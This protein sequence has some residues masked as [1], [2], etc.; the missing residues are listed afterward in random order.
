MQNLPVYLNKG[1]TP[2]AETPYDPATMNQA[3]PE[4]GLF[5]VID[6]IDDHDDNITHFLPTRL[7]GGPWNPSHQHGGAVSGLLTRAL[8]RI[9]SPVPMRLTRI[10]LEMFRGVP[11]TPLRVETRVLR[12]GRRIQ[13]VEASLFDKEMQVAR[14]SGLRIRCEP[15]MSIL[16]TSETLDPIL[17]VPP[18]G[19]VPPVEPRAG[20]EIP[21]GFVNAIDFVR[22]DAPKPGEPATVWARMRC[23][24]MEGEDTAP[25]LRL[26]TLA[27]FASGT[28]NDMD[29]A[30]Y[31]S[32]NPDLTIHVLRE[33]RSEWIGIRGLTRRAEDGIGQSHA[34]IHDLEGP[35]ANVSASLLLDRR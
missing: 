17:G 13:S 3:Q 25:I 15:A 27:D 28:G 19:A 33:P 23:R 18:E 12:A 8:H 29:Y 16:E 34:T 6:N 5:R 10:T 7:A 1:S 2:G 35:I 14:A 20:F 11:M 22:E 30:K 4:D 26:A 21:P 32:I 9:E 31:T 24:L